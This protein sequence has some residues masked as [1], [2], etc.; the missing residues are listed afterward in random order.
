MSK[1]K[2]SYDPIPENEYLLRATRFEET[3]TK[4]GKGTMVKA[5]FEVVNGD[6]KGRLVFENFLVEHTSPMA[7]KIGIERLENYLKAVGVDDGLE[8]LGHDRTQLADYTEIPFIAKV[9]IEEGSEY[10][11]ADGSTRMGKDR[12]KIVSFKAR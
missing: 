4:N 12:N 6:H 1:E 9:V 10:T 11:A 7:Q 2:K 3:K 5:G 8:G